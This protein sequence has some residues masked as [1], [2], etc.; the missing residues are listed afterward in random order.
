MPLVGNAN[1]KQHFLLCS[2]G[3]NDSPY[4]EVFH[5]HSVLTHMQN[6]MNILRKTRDTVV[7]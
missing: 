1:I 3:V 7:A 6:K 5:I 2:I 4:F